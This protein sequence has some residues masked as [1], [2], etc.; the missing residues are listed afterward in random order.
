MIDP[1]SDTII[2]PTTA[3]VDAMTETLS[4]PKLADVSIGFDPVVDKL[5]K[6][7]RPLPPRMQPLGK[8]EGR[9]REKG[10]T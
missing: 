4:D 1:R 3:M 10:N 7:P 6:K 9:P 8:P 2:R 5:E